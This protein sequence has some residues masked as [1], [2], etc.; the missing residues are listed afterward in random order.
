MFDL[1]MILDI[2]FLLECLYEM[3]LELFYFLYFN[4]ISYFNKLS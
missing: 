4:V 2:Y 1:F 3:I